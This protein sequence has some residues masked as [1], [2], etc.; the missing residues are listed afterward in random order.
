M[1]FNLLGLYGELNH[2]VNFPRDDEFHIIYGPNG[3]GKTK[4][5]QVVRALGQLDLRDLMS[6]PFGYAEIEYDDQ[7]KISVEKVATKKLP[8][9][10]GL[11]FR[12]HHPGTLFPI[13]WTPDLEAPFP[14]SGHF[15]VGGSEWRY[16]GGNRWID[17]SDGEIVESDEL[18]ARYD[19]ELPTEDA[20]ESFKLFQGSVH[21]YLIETQR[22]RNYT[23]PQAVFQSRSGRM[24]RVR[25]RRTPQDD[26]VSRYA[27]DLQNRLESALAHNS[28]TTQNL[29]RTFP[30]RLLENI[31]DENE[32]S[33]RFRYATQNQKRERLA[34]LS[35]IGS[36][37]ELPLQ[38]QKLEDW[39]RRV[40]RTYL[41]DTE[42]KLRTFDDILG[43]VDLLEEII[44]QRFKRKKI[45]VNADEGLRID[46]ENSKG[47]IR[48]ED[49]SSG[50]QHE[51][52][53]FYDLLFRTPPGALVMIDEPEIS[54]HIG[55]QRRFLDDI[56]KVAQISG[57]R[58]LVATHSPQIIGNWRHR[59]TALGFDSDVDLQQEGFSEE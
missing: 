7:S 34:E 12:L 37:P 30:R 14:K 20:P 55:W 25:N 10:E 59:A 17:D 29:D 46:V 5:F 3:V 42:S 36:E 54:L 47:Q 24:V 39:Q 58:M 49:L 33:I 11:S 2:S 48:P 41:D 26:A 50:E 4:L 18:R 23:A 32:A 21:S 16:L 27:E 45:S 6:L 22:L 57:S 28:R 53:M 8:R 1:K 31:P 15:T 13:D 51:L 52:I 19:T 40:L 44:N 43:K 56:M 35:L 38:D 9:R